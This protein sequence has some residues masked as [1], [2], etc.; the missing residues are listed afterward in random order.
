MK[1]K[2]GKLKGVCIAVLFCFILSF[3]STSLALATDNVEEAAPL[4]QATEKQ[5]EE[6]ADLGEGKDEEN[7]EQEEKVEEPKEEPKQEEVEEEKP[8]EEEKEEPKVEEKKNIK[9]EVKKEEKKEEE[10]KEEDKQEVTTPVTKVKVFLKARTGSGMSTVQTWTA[11]AGG[12]NTWA[13]A[14]KTAKQYSPIQE[15]KTTY[16]YNGTW[17]DDFGNSYA[18]GDRKQG[19]D[20]IALFDGVEGPEAEMSVYAQY[21]EQTEASLE[22][23]YTD[24]VANGSGSWSDPNGAA[25]EYKHTFK[26]P[27]DIPDNYEFLYWEN[28]NDE[29][30]RYADGE[31]CEISIADLTE[32]TSIE[33]LA[34]Y[35]YQPGTQVIYHYEKDGVKMEYKTE[36][37]REDF[38]VYANAPEGV[39]EWYDEED[40]LIDEGAIFEVPEKILTTEKV[41]D[42][43]TIINVYAKYCDVNLKYVCDDEVL[44]TDTKH[45]NCG[46]PLNADDY[47]ETFDDYEF[48]Y[49]EV[50]YDGNDDNDDDDVSD[51]SDDSDDIDGIGDKKRGNLEEASEGEG[52][53]I[54]DSEGEGEGE[55]YADEGLTIIYHYKK[56]QTEEPT[57]TPGDEPD[58]TPGG[59][60]PTPT[61][62][63][64]P[65]PVTPGEGEDPTP[66]PTD[67]QDGNDGKDGEDGEDGKDGINGNDGKDGTNGKD[68]RDGSKGDNGNNGKDGKGKD[69]KDGTTTVKGGSVSTP[70]NGTAPSTDRQTVSIPKTGDTA[71]TLIWIVGIVLLII[72]LGGLGYTILHWKD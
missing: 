4:P 34:T 69:G 53:D 7:V 12:S 44:K 42:A 56:V 52:E 45:F 58:P 62:G 39:L 16:T 11:V 32:D 46:T 38:D 61:P 43:D 5:V 3:S 26:T 13:N 28:T 48:D 63:N 18:I 66:T 29:E 64:D 70:Y 10:K 14:D 51:D 49:Y 67:G 68:G 35:N 9:K 24:Q 27:A 20:F 60:D 33:F 59:D 41:E 15:G 17:I 54:S 22:V 21:D 1:R 6:A 30:E 40:E 71:N 50:V 37:V 19:A 72:G 23:T 25:T 8:V 55:L 57:P 65:T 2:Y 36:V 47:I 31:T